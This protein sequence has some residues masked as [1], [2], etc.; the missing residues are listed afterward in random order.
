LIADLFAFLCV[1]CVLCGENEFNLNHKERKEHKEIK[2]SQWPLR[3]EF[4]TVLKTL[5]LSWPFPRFVVHFHGLRV[6]RDNESPPSG[7][8][9]GIRPM[10]YDVES[11]SGHAT[12]PRGGRRSPDWT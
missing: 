9:L 3:P 7:G 1:L 5:K 11:Q 8:L 10:R 6:D 4:Q 2:P 12:W